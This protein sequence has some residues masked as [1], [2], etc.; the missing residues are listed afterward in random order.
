[1]YS[2]KPKV[3]QNVVQTISYEFSSGSVFVYKGNLDSKGLKLLIKCKSKVLS[4]FVFLI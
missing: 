2:P 1:M 4:K 3:K